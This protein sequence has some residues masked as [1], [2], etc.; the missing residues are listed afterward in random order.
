VGVKLG[1]VAGAG[2]TVVYLGGAARGRAD[3]A[4]MVFMD[5]PAAAE[6]SERQDQLDRRLSPTLFDE[7]DEDMAGEFSL[8]WKANIEHR[9]SNI[10]WGGK[11]RGEFRSQESEWGRGMVATKGTK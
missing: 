3:T 4:A 6:Y 7:S 9:T 10:E 5:F 1:K 2:G 8:Y 11:G